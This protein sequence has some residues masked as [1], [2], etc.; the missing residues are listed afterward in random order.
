MKE[1]AVN[2]HPVFEQLSGF[3]V[4]IFKTEARTLESFYR[5]LCQMHGFQLQT[6]EVDVLLDGMPAEWQKDLPEKSV[7]SIKPRQA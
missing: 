3:T 4:E 2:Y 5:G 7:L 6:Y 1:V